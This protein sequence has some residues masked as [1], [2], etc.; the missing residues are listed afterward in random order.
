MIGLFLNMIKE[1]FFFQDYKF[2]G[3]YH[4]FQVNEK[5]RKKETN[6]IVESEDSD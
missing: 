2:E 5:L 6:T 3:K 1:I 4:K